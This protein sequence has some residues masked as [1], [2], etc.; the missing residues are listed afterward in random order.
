MCITIVQLLKITGTIEILPLSLSFFKCKKMKFKN[1]K[2]MLSARI[3]LVF[4]KNFGSLL[5]MNIEN[6]KRLFSRG[7][8][9]CR[10]SR[11][12]L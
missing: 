4:V 5:I 8:E 6:C 7:V 3:T 1:V 2:M 9:Y 10:I 12:Y 11:E